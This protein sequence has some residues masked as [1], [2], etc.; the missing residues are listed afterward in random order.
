MMVRLSKNFEL[1]SSLVYHQDY[2]VNHYQIVLGMITNTDDHYEQNIAYERIKFWLTGIFSSSILISN[3]NPLLEQYKA[4]KA[5]LITL[6]DDPVDQLVGIMLCCKLNAITEDRLI[7]TDVDITSVQ[8]DHMIYHH[9]EDENTGPFAMPGWW[10]D[11]RPSF[12]D[13]KDNGKIISISGHNDWK[14]LDLGWEDNSN[15]SN[16][17]VFADFKKD[18]TK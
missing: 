7:I 1:L 12:N 10:N 9:S 13:L 11:P 15:E 2:V 16:T 3:S 17:V 5:R 6:P 8:G 4:T 18:E 14:S